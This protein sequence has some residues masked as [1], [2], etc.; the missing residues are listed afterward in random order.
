MKILYTHLQQADDAGYIG[1]VMPLARIL[2]EKSQVTVAAPASSRLL[3]QAGALP[4][5]RTLALD[6]KGGPLQRLRALSHLR[7]LLRDGRFDVVHVNGLADRRLCMLAT[8]GLGA[9]RPFMVR[10]QPLLA[11]RLQARRAADGLG[12]LGRLREPRA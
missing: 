10:A 6:F 5:V 2:C 3:A 9:R 1:S 8:L 11:Q 7:A 12:A 4:G